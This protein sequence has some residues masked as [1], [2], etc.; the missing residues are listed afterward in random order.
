M[1]GEN[2]IG[3]EETIRELERQA[4]QA[5]RDMRRELTEK[6]LAKEVPF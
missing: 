2:R 4:V 6:E 3:M 1:M 5:E